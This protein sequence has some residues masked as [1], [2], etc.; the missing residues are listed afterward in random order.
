MAAAEAAAIS[1]D[2][3]EGYLNEGSFDGISTHGIFNFGS[4]VS[5]LGIT[6]LITAREERE[7]QKDCEERE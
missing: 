5:T 6:V 1:I 3:T 7:G 2:L 4:I